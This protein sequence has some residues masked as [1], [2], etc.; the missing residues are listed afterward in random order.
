MK[1]FWLYIPEVDEA[2]CVAQGDSPEDA[3]E[4]AKKLGFYPDPGAEIQIHEL[5]ESTVIYAP[6]R[7]FIC[8]VA[9]AK[10]MGVP[11]CQRCANTYPTYEL[12]RRH[13]KHEMKEASA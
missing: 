12:I 10:D 4:N 5:G 3:L 6:K 7:C 9:P 11:C 8:E 1:H 13:R 2:G